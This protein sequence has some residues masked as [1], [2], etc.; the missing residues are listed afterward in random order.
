MTFGR[1]YTSPAGTEQLG[2]TTLLSTADIF[3]YVVLVLHN[4]DILTHPNQGNSAVSLDTSESFFFFLH[5][6]SRIHLEDVLVTVLHHFISY[7][8]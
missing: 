4:N 7:T 3:D 6:C 2:A 8:F 1:I 5:K